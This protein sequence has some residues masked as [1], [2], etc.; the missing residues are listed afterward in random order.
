MT[1]F[2]IIYRLFDQLTGSVSWSVCNKV[3]WLNM[4]FLLPFVTIGFGDLDL[5]FTLSNE[6]L[7]YSYAVDGDHPA[8]EI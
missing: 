1:T 8:K 7:R 5:C 4:V 2:C 6:I 3:C